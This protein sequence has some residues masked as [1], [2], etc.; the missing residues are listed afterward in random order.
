MFTLL[1]WFL[2]AKH[3]IAHC[4]GWNEGRMEFWHARCGKQMVGF[5]CECGRLD[6]IRPCSETLS[7]IDP[8]EILTHP[9]LIEYQ[10]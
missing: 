2:E 9:E 10:P 1:I 8:L 6:G 5:R 7:F 4:L 3:A